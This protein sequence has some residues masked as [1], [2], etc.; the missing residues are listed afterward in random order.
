MMNGKSLLLR[1]NMKAFPP[2]GTATSMTALI[3]IVT[4][5][6][7]NSANI[8]AKRIMEGFPYDVIILLISMELFTNLVA[9]SGVLD[10]LATKLSLIS[11]GQKRLCLF[12]FGSLMFVVSCVL[13]NITAVMVIL[14]VVFVLL[15]SI[16]VDRRYSNIFFAAMLSLSNTGGAASPIGDF[17]AMVIMT[18]GITTFTRYLAWAFPL[19]LAT[20]LILLVGWCS[21]VQDSA[22]DGERNLGVMLL[23]S[24]YRNHK[25]RWDVVAGVGIVFLVMFL[26]WSVVPQEMAPPEC[27]AVLGYVSSAAFC[28]WRGVSVKQD[29]DL[30]T[31]WL[32]ASFLCFSTTISQT[33]WL[34]SVAVKLQAS[35]AD[36]V[37]LLITI[38]LMTSLCAG[39]F[40]AGPAAA[41]MMPVVKELCS[42]SFAGQAD[43]V[44]VA[45]AAS[46][47]AG[48]SL[49]M[50][51]ATAGFLLSDRV[52][53]ARLSG[54]DRDGIEWGFNDYFIF[55]LANYTLQIS[56]AIAWM[57]IARKCGG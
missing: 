30:R 44:A 25:A 7:A 35:I 39:F 57:L 56:L 51:S 20:S 49:L 29:V 16:G 15:R 28:R 46:I 19:F 23:Q 1:L 40:S 10:W 26:A 8:P 2:G 33:G 34:S 24:Q 27:I 42:T 43:L 48:S 13:N 41:A 53:Q 50:S 14:P 6:V 31:V 22:S 37:V 38:M 5:L 45:Y 12:C 32:L 18:S 36:P 21:F 54:D 55:G 3:F 17:P 47:C 4:L 52:K 11:R 9:E